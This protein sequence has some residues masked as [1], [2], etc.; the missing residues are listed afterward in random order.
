MNKESD[1]LTAVSSRYTVGLKLWL[2]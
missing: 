1:R 2:R